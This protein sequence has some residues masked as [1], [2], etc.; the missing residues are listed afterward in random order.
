MNF[1]TEFVVVEKSDGGI[2][3]MRAAAELTPVEDGLNDDGLYG[4]GFRSRIAAWRWSLPNPGGKLS[5]G[6][7]RKLA[8]KEV[9]IGFFPI[10]SATISDRMDHDGDFMSQ[11]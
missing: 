11:L 1:Q 6:E 4:A 7:E 10:F 8:E 9:F 5:R 3:M 2:K